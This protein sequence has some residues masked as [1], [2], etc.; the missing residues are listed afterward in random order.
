[1]REPLLVKKY[2]VREGFSRHRGISKRDKQKEGGGKGWESGMLGIWL[3]GWGVMG[4]MGLGQRERAQS[5]RRG[6]GG[7]GPFC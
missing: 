5:T 3:D 6:E 2:P 1:M 4:G 7:E